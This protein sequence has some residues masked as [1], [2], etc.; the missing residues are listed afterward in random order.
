VRDVAVRTLDASTKS[1]P[2]DTLIALRNKLR[3]TVAL[4]GEDGYDTARAIWNAT[5]DRS[6]GLVV[7]CRGAADVIRAVELARD[8]RA[9]CRHPN[10]RC[11]P[12][13]AVPWRAWLPMPPHGRTATLTLS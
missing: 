5:V 6:P 2:Q 7:R 4:P 3:G 13:S 8:E 9:H 12:I 1:I 10:A 11:S